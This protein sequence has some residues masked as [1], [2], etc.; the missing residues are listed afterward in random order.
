MKRRLLAAAA[1]VLLPIACMLCLFSCGK[2][3]PEVVFLN[4]GEGNAALIRT[5]AGDILIDA[6]PEDSQAMLC[7]RLR[8]LGVRELALL[9]LTHPDEDHIGGADGVLQ[10][11]PVQEI[12]TNGE[13]ADTDSY[14]ALLRAA[15]SHSIRTVTAGERWTV[16]NAAITVLSPTAEAAGSENENGLVLL[17]EAAGTRLLLM[18]DAGQ[19]TE[20]RLLRQAGQ[21]NLQADILLAGHHGSDSASGEAFLAAVAPRQIVISCGAGNAYGHPD[22]RALARMQA[23]CD[24]IR[25]TDLEGEVHIQLGEGV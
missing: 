2:L 15:G 12:W 9:I 5:A 14:D 7:E 3:T 22:G 8:Q 13:T 20:A 6:G 4:V 21:V 18:G 19:E 23:V 10:A 24:R 11:F 25:R 16:G 1:A 17:A